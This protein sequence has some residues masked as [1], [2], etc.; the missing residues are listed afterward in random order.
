MKTK[1]K[2]VYRTSS[3]MQQNKD[4]KEK[5]ARMKIYR[6]SSRIQTGGPSELDFFRNLE[7]I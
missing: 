1:T 2:K 6:R 4:K 7:R 3:R 5:Q